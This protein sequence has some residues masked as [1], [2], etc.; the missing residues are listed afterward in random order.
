MTGAS[1]RSIVS[2]LWG[3]GILIM[4][5][6]INAPCQVGVAT[7]HYDNFR[8]GQN[9]HE[10]ILKPSIVT[11]KTFGKLFAQSVDGQIYGEPLYRPNLVI[12]GKGLHNLVFVAT[13]HDSV[14]AFDADHNLDGN[15]APLWHVNFLN[16]A[17]GI[18]TIPSSDVGTKMIS[19]EIGITSTPV[20]DTSTGTLYVVAA[21]KENGT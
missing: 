6:V 13:E 2:S 15:A 10:T 9:N 21:T 18:T 19:P 16:P 8:T 11:A 5:A 20:I 3:C 7:Y 1:P 12:P 17:N 4:A 14:Y